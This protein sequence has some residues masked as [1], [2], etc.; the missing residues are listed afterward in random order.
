MKIVKEVI[1]VLLVTVISLALVYLSMIGIQKII[2]ISNYDPYQYLEVNDRQ[3]ELD[4][5]ATLNQ[6]K[7]QAYVISQDIPY[8]VDYKKSLVL[9]RYEFKDNDLLID[10]VVPDIDHKLGIESYINKEDFLSWTTDC[11]DDTSKFLINNGMRI[12]YSFYDDD[13]NLMTEWVVDSCR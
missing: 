2:N 11:S 1:I 5:E 13:F 10:Y 3:S 9:D 12:I 4:F 8:V 6:W 7:A